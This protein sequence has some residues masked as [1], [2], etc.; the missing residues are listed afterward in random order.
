[1]SIWRLMEILTLQDYLILFVTTFF[2]PLL[3][4]GLHVLI[5]GKLP[6]GNPKK[7]LLALRDF[8]DQVLY[9]LDK[10]EQEEQEE[11]ESKSSRRRVVH[12]YDVW[13]EV[14][15][16]TGEVGANTGTRIRHPKNRDR[17]YSGSVER[18]HDGG[19]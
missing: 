19:G 11:R 15:Y 17:A 10:I 9:E 13:E 3:F 6:F 8:K 1:M 7:D 2:W 18:F 4:G 16:D 14:D 5:L 12:D